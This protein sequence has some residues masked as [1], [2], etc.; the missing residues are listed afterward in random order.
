[1]FI[2]AAVGLPA[3]LHFGWT[4]RHPLPSEIDDALTRLAADRTHI[5]RRL[6]WALAGLA[7]RGKSPC[8]DAP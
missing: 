7:N 5:Q 1:M 4:E 6:R 3:L 2:M 8:N